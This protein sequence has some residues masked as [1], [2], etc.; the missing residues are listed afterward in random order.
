M[1]KNSVV[2]TSL[3]ELFAAKP[4]RSAICAGAFAGAVS[5]L[6]ALL[7]VLVMTAN[8]SGSE[9][10]GSA[11]SFLVGRSQ[12]TFFVIGVLWAPLFET[13]IG[14]IIPLEFLRLLGVNV[15][16]CLL[17]SAGLFAFGHYLNG[18]GM[19]QM[20]ATFAGGAIFSGS[21]L[22]LRALG[23]WPA[24]IAAATAHATHNGLLMFV[25]A[26]LFPKLS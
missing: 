16:F 3:R 5:A 1:Q 22:A 17:I 25:I 18:A 14:Q 9:M 19:L 4:V 6:V 26:P 20:T 8:F 12:A 13:I 24:Y 23:L 15:L 7:I 2:S 10:G 21:Y 11:A